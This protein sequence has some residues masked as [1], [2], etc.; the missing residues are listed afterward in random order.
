[1]F[2]FDA[3]ADF[4]GQIRREIDA[5]RGRGVIKLIDVLVVRKEADGQIVTREIAQ[6]TAAER[7]D[8]GAALRRLLVPIGADSAAADDGHANPDEQTFGINVAETQALL[9]A[10]PPGS[11]VA[12]ALFE[13]RWA[14]ELSAVIRESG[15][16]LLSQ[17]LLTRDAALL[18]GAELEAMT[19]AQAAIELAE[20][21]K[22]AAMLD[23]LAFAAE[24]E[25]IKSEAA[26]EAA[27]AVAGSAAATIVAV[28]TVRTLIAAGL[29]D[30]VEAGWAL[31]ALT[32]AGMLDPAI[33]DEA[34][35]PAAQQAA[36]SAG[37]VGAR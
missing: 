23:A 14:A 13:H 6:A 20:S 7:A 29:L 1:V 19:A 33:I 27:T 35:A 28:E 25:E 24:V 12:V 9:E 26:A 22:S 18:I 15:G 16:H 30:D 21:V 17:G 4:H 32:E 31:D 37:Y 8:Y 3:G 34:A 2:R 10:L 5:T 11:A 36:H